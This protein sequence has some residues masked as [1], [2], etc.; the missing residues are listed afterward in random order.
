MQYTTTTTST[1]ATNKHSFSNLDKIFWTETK[2][3]GALTKRDLI[4]YYDAIGDYLLQK[5][6]ILFD[7]VCHHS[8]GLLVLFCLFQI[9]LLIYLNIFWV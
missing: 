8:F 6:N 9:A 5:S 1:T 7:I 4:D 3:H 2:D